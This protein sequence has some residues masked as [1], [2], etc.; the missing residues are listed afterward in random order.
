ME[1]FVPEETS[2]QLR[3]LTHSSV[4]VDSNSQQNQANS[5]DGV[6]TARS[7]L[8]SGEIVVVSGDTGLSSCAGGPGL[9]QSLYWLYRATVSQ[10]LYL[11][12]FVV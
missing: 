6:E 5:N 11:L 9:A 10:I 7:I 8:E 12:S 3:Q 1:W 2:Q 4:D